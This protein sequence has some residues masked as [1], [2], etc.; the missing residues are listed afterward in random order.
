MKFGIG[1][2]IK[3]QDIEDGQLDGV[4][5]EVDKDEFERIIKDIEKNDAS[6]TIINN[7]NENDEICF[8]IV[9]ANKWK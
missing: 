6:P 5:H 2:T 7:R 1:I 4:W 8:I 9:G 3:E